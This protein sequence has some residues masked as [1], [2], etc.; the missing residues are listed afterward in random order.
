MANS[1]QVIVLVADEKDATLSANNDGVT[2]VLRHMERVSPV[3]DTEEDCRAGAI[4]R[5]I[6]ACQIMMAL[7]RC[8]HEHD[9]EGVIIFA[10]AAM[11]E[12]LRRVQTGT[13][14]RLLLAQIVGKPTDA[15]RFPGYSAANA[16]MAY[17]GGLQ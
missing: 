8:A 1:S 2:R 13:V 5:H 17:C 7:S 6:F 3:N 15:C 16:Q 11:M 14:T 10:A 4:A 9:C 12:E